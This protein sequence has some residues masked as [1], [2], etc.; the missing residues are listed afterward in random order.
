M[1]RR[2]IVRYI[3]RVLAICCGYGSV[4]IDLGGEGSGL[5]N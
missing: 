5:G 3:A 4:Q 1:P 2:L